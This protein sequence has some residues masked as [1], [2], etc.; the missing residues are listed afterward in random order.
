M[1]EDFYFVYGYTGDSA[2]RLYRYVGGNFERF[3]SENAAWQPD[4]EQCRIFVGE[5]LEYEEITEEQA[6]SIKV[7]S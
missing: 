1:P 7:L 4:P 3:D 6:N 5:D 2:S